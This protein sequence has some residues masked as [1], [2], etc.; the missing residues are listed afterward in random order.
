MPLRAG[1]GLT[2]QR[3]GVGSRQVVLIWEVSPVSLVDNCLRI[4][5]LRIVYQRHRAYKIKD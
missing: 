2:F 5:P 4:L 1:Y 3:R